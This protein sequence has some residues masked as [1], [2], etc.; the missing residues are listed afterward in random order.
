[1]TAKGEYFDGEAMVKSIEEN[2]GTDKIFFGGMAGDNMTFSGTY[3][4]THSWE[5]DFGIAAIVIDG[6]KLSL[7]G[8][9]ITG[10]QPIGI[11]RTVTKSIGNKIYT[12]DN[13][14][15]VEMYFKYL[16]KEEK[17][18]DHDFKVFEELGYTYP[19]IQKEHPVVK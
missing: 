9:A 3:V 10:W 14:S 12:I 8:M 19:F 15:A 1:M 4:F 11:T 6:E 16:G 13:R 7:S 5:T 18:S 2:I 17:K